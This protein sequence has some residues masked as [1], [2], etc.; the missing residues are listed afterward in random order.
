MSFRPF[1]SRGLRSWISRRRPTT[2][3]RGALSEL[4]Q[5][6]A[7]YALVMLGAATVALLLLAW[8]MRTGA[9]G[10]LL[11]AVIERLMGEIAA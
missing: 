3:A 1:P 6:T 11:D 5:A 2:A 7:E 4:G 9:V 8:A 10:R